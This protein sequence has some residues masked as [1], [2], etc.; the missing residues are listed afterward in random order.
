MKIRDELTLATT[1]HLTDLGVSILADGE[2]GLV[3]EIA[4]GHSETCAQCIEHIAQTAEQTHL[5]AEAYKHEAQPVLSRGVMAAVAFAT[6]AGALATLS[7][8]NVLGIT[9]GFRTLERALPHV[10]RSLISF[11][12]PYVTVS[13]TLAIALTATLVF[14]TQNSTKVKS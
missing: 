8:I 3:S 6:L 11:G 1:R 4:L 13:A 5:L 7:R 9:H 14:R 12:G 2:A 10:A